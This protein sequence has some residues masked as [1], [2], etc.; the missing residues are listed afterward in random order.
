MRPSLKSTLVDH[1]QEHPFTLVND[2]TSDC[3]VQ[4]MNVLC[5]YIFHINNS[6]RVEFNSYGMCATSGGHCSKAI[7]LFNKSDET[8]SKD[9]IDSDNVISF[10]LDN[11]NLNMGC[12][13]SLKTRIIEKN[14]VAF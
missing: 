4:K 11:T 12:H 6:K 10:G 5:A 7:T 8:L 13:S 9:S 14:S 1:M 2:G 3:G